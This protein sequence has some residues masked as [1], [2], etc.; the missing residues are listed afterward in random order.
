MMV[1]K[2]D[3][4]GWLSRSTSLYAHGLRIAFADL[5]WKSVPMSRR[6]SI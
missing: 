5:R 1:G 6:S 2:A 3:N 4:R